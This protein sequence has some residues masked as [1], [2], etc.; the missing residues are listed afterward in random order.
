M[1]ALVISACVFVAMWYFDGWLIDKYYLTSD[2]YSKQDIEHVKKLQAEIDKQQLSTDDVYQIGYWVKEEGISELRIYKDKELIY[3]SECDV[4]QL[5]DDQKAMLYWESYYPV[6]FSDCEVQVSIFGSY[7]YRIYNFALVGEILMAF[8]AFLIVI[9]AGMKKK[10]NYI[11]KLSKELEI[12]EGGDLAYKI[13]VEGKDELAA[14]ARG[15]DDMRVSF[16][17]QMM[18]ETLIV[19]ENRRIVTEMSHDLRTP[20]TSIMLYSDILKSGKYK[21]KEQMQEYLNII[22]EKT[23]KLKQMT[24]HLFEYALITDDID[25]KMEE[26]QLPE[27]VFYDLISELYGYLEH[28]GF[29]L[30]TEFNWPDESI[31]INTEYIARVFDNISSNIVK[32]ADRNDDIKIVCCQSNDCFRLQFE[33]KINY[34]SNEEDSSGI[35]LKSIE[36]MMNRMGGNSIVKKEQDIFVLK[37]YFPII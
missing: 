28:N 13:T 23:L 21:S 18:Q 10:M 33:N 37:L 34:A 25:I 22:N 24:D 26:P 11:S 29:K 36:N 14:L 6:K 20:L 32:Y 30:E 16:R 4:S 15:I 17:M 5:E 35:G 2:M 27:N 19:N 8:I 31:R 12:L 7:N 9:V 3:D 1:L